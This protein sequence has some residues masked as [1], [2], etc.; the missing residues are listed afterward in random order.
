MDAVRL[1]LPF[2][3]TS[4]SMASYARPTWGR[5]ANYSRLELFLRY[6]A[7]VEE[8]FKE[9]SGFHAQRLQSA[10]LGIVAT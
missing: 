5:E 9:A 1:I 8:E 7:I 2:R 3:Q 6:A 10:Y 4:R